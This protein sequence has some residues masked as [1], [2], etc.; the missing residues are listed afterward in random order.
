MCEYDTC[1]FVINSARI[2]YLE[3]DDD[4]LLVAMA[5]KQR[6]GFVFGSILLVGLGGAQSQLCCVDE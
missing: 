2:N 6:L 3:E 4:R 1:S 5:L